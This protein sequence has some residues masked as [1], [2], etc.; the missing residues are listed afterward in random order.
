MQAHDAANRQSAQRV[1]LGH[2]RPEQGRHDD[3]AAVSDTR[4]HSK[5][6]GEIRGRG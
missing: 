3:R 1:E 4:G 5:V 6:I 2:D